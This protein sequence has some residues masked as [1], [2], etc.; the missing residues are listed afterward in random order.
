MQGYDKSRQVG[1]TK[2]LEDG[3]HEVYKTDPWGN[4][5]LVGAADNE[6]LAGTLLV[7][8]CGAETVV[9]R[10]PNPEPVPDPV[11]A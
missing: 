1:Y 7:V 6:E 5:H 4:A 8:L 2:Q 11:P 9:G 3:S 10:L